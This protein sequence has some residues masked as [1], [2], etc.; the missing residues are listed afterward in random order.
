[1]SM[2]DE[3][4]KMHCP[5]GVKAVKLVDIFE[6]ANTG[7][8]KTINPDEKMVLL[9]NYM[10]VY[11]KN[12]ISKN[13]LTMIVS[14]NDRKIIQ[15]DIKRGDVFITP[16]SETI[17]DIGHSSVIMEDIPNAVYS[18]H[19]MR[20]RPKTLNIVTSI[21]LS[22]LFRSNIIQSQITSIATGMTRYG[23]SKSKFENLKFPLP[24]IEVQQEIVRILDTFT[25]L[26]VTLE[27][28]LESRKKQYSFYRDS[29]ISFEQDITLMRLG[30]IAT[31]MYRGSGI[32]RDEV[33]EFGIPCVRYGEIYTTYN[34]WF[35][36]CVSKANKDVIQNKKYFG[37]GDILFAITGE[38]VSEIAKST[39]YLGHDVCLA[40]GD[41]VVMKHEQNPRYMA[42]VLSTSNAQAQKSKGRV[43]SKVVHSSIPA[44]R[45][46]NIPIPTLSEQDRIANILDNFN[47]L[48]NDKS[49]GLPAEIAA[50]RKQFEY[51]RNKLLTFKE[52]EYEPV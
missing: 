7:V 49:E 20:L 36:K 15:C 45:E 26:V 6:I 12:R 52:V 4:I 5:N 51:Y 39:V 22:Y 29:L 37:H 11:R 18:Y 23:L 9:L 25:M 35:D 31:S 30:D 27:A 1:M 46:I 19:I 47:F 32:K 13:D 14:A 28:E 3:L 44:L 50:R 16:T 40:G 42:Y 17:D 34:T 10:D 38:S 33:T 48:I 21:Y 8:D 2:L 24:P 41:I 43:K